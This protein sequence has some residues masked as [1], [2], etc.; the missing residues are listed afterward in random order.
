MSLPVGADIESL[1]SK[2]G[3]VWHVVVAKVGDKIAKVLCKQCGK[4]HR[5]KPPERAASAATAASAPAR[6]TTRA[7]APEPA[8][9]EPLVPFD[10]AVPPRPYRATES[11]APGERVAHPTFGT[12]VV[13]AIPGPGKIQVFFKDGRRVLA[14][15][16]S[17][18]GLERRG[19]PRP[20]EGG[21]GV[22]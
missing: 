12:G 14:A 4:E 1:C 15:A 11:F 9:E 16:K 6:R 3:D 17:A 20:G 22:G 13:E 8:V 5:Y 19:P 2:C 7:A 18:S 21:P 10:P